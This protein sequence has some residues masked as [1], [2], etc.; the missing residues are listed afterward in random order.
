MGG[1]KGKSTMNNKWSCFN[2]G[3]NGHWLQDCYL[4]DVPCS[5]GCQN[6]MKLLWSSKQTSFNCRFLKCPNP[7]CKAFTWVDNPCGSSFTTNQEGENSN[8][9]STNLTTTNN[10][11][12]TS[13]SGKKNIKV[14]VEEHGKKITF[15][16]E[17]DAV[18]DVLNKKFNV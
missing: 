15:E 10:S 5:K 4:K 12:V 13:D 7:K 17:V 1:S 16:G 18:I 8:F 2:C 14:T 11:G 9:A 3:E 6:V